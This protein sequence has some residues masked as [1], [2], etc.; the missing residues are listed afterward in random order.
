M[1]LFLFFFSMSKLSVLPCLLAFSFL[2][3]VQNMKALEI[4][5]IVAGSIFATFCLARTAT[6]L[7]RWTKSLSTLV[8]RHLVLPFLV[9]RHRLL[10]PWSWGN[11]LLHLS[12]ITVN[13]FLVFFGGGSFL[14][15][16]HRAGI[17]A[18]INLIFLLSAMHLSFL[19]DLMGISLRNCQR[20]H[21]AVGWTTVVLQAFHIIIVAR[22]DFPLCE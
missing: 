5:G 8:N 21:R 2:A 16:Y 19:A 13:I 12:Y 7:A 9:G 11:V 17:L 1:P 15:A 20:V 14:S 6:T 22:V 18:S 4:Y 10:S 3:I